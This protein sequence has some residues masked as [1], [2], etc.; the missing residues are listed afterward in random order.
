M[1]V[2]VIRGNFQILFGKKIHANTEG[3]LVWNVLGKAKAY[4]REAKMCMLCL[5]GKYHIIFSNLN[6]LNSRNELVAKCCHEK[7]ISF[8]LL[9]L[10]ITSRSF[11]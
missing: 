5:T 8:T 9:N 11:T 6:L 7:K 2:N 3:N 10:K 4:K 1:K